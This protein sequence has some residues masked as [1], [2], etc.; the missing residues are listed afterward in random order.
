[1]LQEEKIATEKRKLD[2]A[3]GS[4]RIGKDVIELKNVSKRFGSRM[5]F[6]DVNYLATP[7]ERLGI[8]GDNG[9]GKTTLLNIMAGKEDLDSGE[10][11][12]GK[13]VKIGYYTQEHEPL[14]SNMRMIDYV[15]E[16][17]EV[18]HTIDGTVITAEQ[19]LE[20]FLFPRSVQRTH[21]RRLSGGER[22]RLYLLKVLM[23]EPNVLFLDEPTNDLD[24]ETL[25]VLE[26]Y[27]E[28]FPGVVITV[29][30]DRYFLDRV[31][32]KLLVFD[33]NG[34]V[35]LF[36]GSY[37]EWFKTKREEEFHKSDIKNKGGETPKRQSKSKKK[38]LS[39]N[40]QREWEHIEEKITLLENKL[41][42][43]EQRII[44]A[45]SNIDEV[46]NLYDEQKEVEAELEKSIAR[47]EE[48]A[49]LVEE[50]ENEK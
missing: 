17:A 23:E 45:G 4:T 7:S 13:T 26:D 38:K 24:T 6:Q 49:I 2:F 27:L 12:I 36:H 14:D 21:I 44:E 39:Y 42:E 1:M 16:Q 35:S 20:R 47:W 28:Q 48:L 37:S 3:I 31:V 33:G 43:L 30:H 19:M 11:A 32:D 29:S 8:V 41:S 50:M 46:R 18:V 40:E 25:T 10:V 15:K 34:N 5:L 9:V 22:K